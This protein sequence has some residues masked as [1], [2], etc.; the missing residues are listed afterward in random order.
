MTRH[1]HVKIY[2]LKRQIPKHVE[3]INVSEKPIYDSSLERF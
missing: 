2:H 3:I 1:P